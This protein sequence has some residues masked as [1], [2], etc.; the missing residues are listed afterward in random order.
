MILIIPRYGYELPPQKFQFYNL[1][2]FYSVMYLNELPAAD[3]DFMVVVG[4]LCPELVSFHG[5]GC[6]VT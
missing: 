5:D 3:L 6:L 2:S 1:L 4:K